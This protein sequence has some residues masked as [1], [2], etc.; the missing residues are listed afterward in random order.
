MKLNL[1]S[2]PDF[3]ER[4]K[5]NS[6]ETYLAF[7]DLLSLLTKETSRKDS[8]IFLSKIVKA[9]CNK[10]FNCDYFSF[11][12]QKIVK[13]NGETLTLNLL[14]FRSIFVPNA[15]S[16]TF[17]EGLSRYPISDF[18]N[19]QITELGCG[20]G[21]VVLA[22]AFRTLP[23]KIFGL[24]INPRAI[25]ASKL[26]L[27]LNGLSDDG[28]L[29]IGEDE[30]P[31]IDK[32]EFLQSDLLQELFNRELTLDRVIGCIPQVLNPEPNSFRE[33]ITDE[34]LYDLSN[35]YTKQGYVED[36]FG[37]GLIAKAIEQSALILKPSGKIILNLGG[38][39]G[40]VVLERLMS[41]RGFGV[42]KIWQTKV[43]QDIDTSIDS[44]VEIEKA[45]GH[46]FEFY[47]SEHSN[48]A[49]SAITAKAC[50]LHNHP[51]YHSVSVY[52]GIM[53]NPVPLKKIIKILNEDKYLDVRSALDL[54]ENE[55]HL[56]EERSSFLAMILEYLENVSYFP[57][58]ESQGETLL[59]QKLI[60]YLKSYF[61][62]N[63]NLSHTIVATN[64]KSLISNILRLFDP[65]NILVNKDIFTL[66][67]REVR[68]FSTK[69]QIIASPNDLNVTLQLIKLLKPNFII[70][71]FEDF[72]AK[73]EN[74]IRELI[75]LTNETNS[76]LLLDLS[77]LIEFSS[78]PLG[79]GIFEYFAK[80]S[81]PDHVG[82]F[83][84]L[85]NNKVYPDFE[86]SFFVASDTSLITFLTD[87]AELTYSRTPLLTQK[88]Y[89]HLLE[90][91]LFFQVEKEYKN[92]SKVAKKSSQIYSQHIQELHCNPVIIENHLNFTKDSIRLD[93]GENCLPVATCIKR[94][95]AES[96][97]L[98][99]LKTEECNPNTA[100][101]HYLFKRFN[102][103]N[104]YKYP[105]ILNGGVSE[106]YSTILDECNKN[107]DIFILPKVVYGYFA[108]A[109]ILHQTKTVNLEC[110]Y[111]NKF[112]I[113]TEK[114]IELVSNSKDNYWLYLNLP[115]VNPTGISYTEKELEILFEIIEKYNINLVIDTIFSGLNFIKDNHFFDLSRLNYLKNKIFLLGGISKEFSCA[116]IRFGFS[117]CLNA[118]LESSY[119]I[120]V[121]TTRYAIKKLYEA[122]NIDLPELVEHQ[123]QQLKTLKLRA[124]I[125][126]KTLTECGWEVLP[127][128]GGLFLV[129]KPTFYFGKEF[130][131]N[132][133]TW[134][135]DESNIADV[136]FTYT[137]LTINRPAWTGIPQYCRFVLSVEQDQFNEALNRIKTFYEKTNEFTK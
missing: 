67:N 66:L 95:L 103:T 124:Q 134:I 52:Q 20:N 114:L 69:N 13:Y 97:V 26:N 43:K 42:R 28:E 90:E 113:N 96:F 11:I 15:W 47:F 51:I 116:G 123:A 109:T 79:C 87:A 32:V 133:K 31:I 34:L 89:S 112:K 65:Q 76:F 63:W 23:Q 75:N 108:T 6:R 110:D 99:S 9:W 33:I 125:L 62:I 55:P 2:L 106:S 45:T 83:F 100:I 101:N 93:Y 14:S 82:L 98:K 25:L 4:C 71:K 30:L 137:G 48:V 102:L 127:P 84:G 1:S 120:P 10:E 17:Y 27:A 50:L 92:T 132:G 118:T 57:Y 38:R 131:I 86:L 94:F 105:L 72:E 60:H 41:R 44:L 29:I 128:E 54:T 19:K 74:G 35:Y 119:S 8:R 126:Q 115:L 21:W 81:L 37:L 7:E 5:T 64:R 111:N 85:I 49:M 117:L 56:A 91:L 46:N 24:D 16:Y 88:Y 22:L 130:Y 78:E 53:K 68:N 18:N 122:I 58:G 136:I 70:T 36:Q 73:T 77:N 59:R 39:P 3:I 61:G 129:A 40:A 135:L 80:E 12:K 104:T 121:A 107:N